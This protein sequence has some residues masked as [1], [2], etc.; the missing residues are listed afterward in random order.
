MAPRPRKPKVRLDIRKLA[1]LAGVAPSALRYYEREGL[2]EPA[3][4]AAGRRYY[5]EKGLLQLAA[6]EYWQEAGF[7]L[8][9][10]SRLFDE[11]ASGMAEVK[12]LAKERIAELDRL[13]EHATTV[14][15]LLQHVTTCTHAKMSQCPDY[16]AHMRRRADAM[17]SGTYSRAIHALQPIHRIASLSRTGARRGSGRGPAGA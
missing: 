5:D 7:T 15:G 13:I 12:E 4:R 1:E 9:E 10:M 3:G 8:S 14:R 2:L 11:S 17:Q 16:R 6:I